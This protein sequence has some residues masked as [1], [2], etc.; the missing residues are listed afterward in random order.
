MNF[1]FH[2][3]SLS[4]VYVHLLNLYRKNSSELPKSRTFVK[5]V[6]L[7]S[8][9]KNARWDLLGLTDQK[10]SIYFN[11]SGHINWNC[12]PIQEIFLG[13]EKH[14]EGSVGFCL[15]Q[16]TLHLLWDL[17]PLLE[18]GSFNYICISRL[19][20]CGHTNWTNDRELNKLQPIKFSLPGIWNIDNELVTSWLEALEPEFTCGSRNKV[21]IFFPCVKAEKGQ[22]VKRQSK[23][24]KKRQEGTL[25]SQQGGK[26]YLD[27]LGSWMFSSFWFVSFMKA[28]SPRVL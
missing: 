4:L 15:E 18:V 5:I 26:C 14:P 16:P 2:K 8:S 24:A 19:Q 7:G 25:T 28:N 20:P 13:K 12:Q 10:I 27:C 23:Q 6:A 1:Y 3:P 22:L 21:V 17:H 11:S 9:S